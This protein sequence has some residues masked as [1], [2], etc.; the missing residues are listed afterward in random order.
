VPQTKSRSRRKQP[1]AKLTVL[2][3]KLGEVIGLAMAAKETTKK[4]EGLEGAEPFARALQ[5]M[6]KEAEAAEKSGKQAARSFQGKSTAINAKA[7]ET[8]QKAS[9][10]MNTYLDRK[11]DALDGF[12]FITMAEAGEV[13]HWAALAK[14]N[15][16]AKNPEIR[17]IV[18]RNL[19]VQ[20]R[21]LRQ[22]TTT[23]LKLASQEDPD[24]EE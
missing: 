22:A 2:E 6:R 10:M 4:V 24:E 21:H 20:E 5:K 16:K 8:K 14:L 3:S 18:E 7:R 13:G 19:P 9:K 15:Q 11:S 12:E 1:Q 23:T 17:E